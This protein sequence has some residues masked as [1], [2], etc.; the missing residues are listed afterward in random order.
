MSRLSAV[1]LAGLVC[2]VGCRPSHIDTNQQ[3]LKR[4]NHEK[5]DER[6]KAAWDIAEY[7]PLPAEFV[8]PLLNLLQ[9]DK[10]PNVREA[11]AKALRQGGPAVHVQMLEIFKTETEETVRTAIMGVINAAPAK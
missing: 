5:S 4:L 2:L 10:Q 11:A 9:H 6:I 3:L 7:A 1:C 8:E